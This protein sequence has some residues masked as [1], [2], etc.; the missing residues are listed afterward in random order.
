MHAGYDQ[1][2]HR[3]GVEERV[4]FIA[5]QLPAVARHQRIHQRSVSAVKVL[6]KD[7]ADMGAELIDPPHPPTEFGEGGRSSRADRVCT[8]HLHG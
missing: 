8:F 4:Q 2:V 5:R 1:Q 3:A 7:A 6:L